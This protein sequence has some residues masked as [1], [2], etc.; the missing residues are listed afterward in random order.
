MNYEYKRQVSRAFAGIGFGG[1]YPIVIPELDLV[2]VFTGWNILA[3]G[4]RMSSQ[5]AIKRI[6]AAVIEP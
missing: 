6:L 5:E 2:I 1:Q 3:E 4:P